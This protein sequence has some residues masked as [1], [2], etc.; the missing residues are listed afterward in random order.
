[1]EAHL[2][3]EARNASSAQID[4]LPT[5]DMLRVINAADAEIAGAVANEIPAI[6][7]A[8]D[9]I[10]A[11]LQNGGTGSKVELRV[12]TSKTGDVR[13]VGLQRVRVSTHAVK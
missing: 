6:S 5:G 3:T 9:G 7:R 1:M 4:E 10:V 2:T 13:N 12:R 8:V 11:R